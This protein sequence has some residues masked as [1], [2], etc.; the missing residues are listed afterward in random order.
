[1]LS[2]SQHCDKVVNKS[3]EIQ[4]ATVGV[5]RDLEQV[6][7]EE[8]MRNFSFFSLPPLK[9]EKMVYT[10]GL[11]YSSKLCYKEISN[12]LFSRIADHREEI[13]SESVAEKYWVL[14]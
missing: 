7:Y 6:T 5:K 3:E 14:Y 12:Y 4:S 9:K 10:N 11:Q 1:M 13:S 8:N 2:F